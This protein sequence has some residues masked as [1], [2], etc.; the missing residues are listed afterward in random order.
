MRIELRKASATTFDWGY[1]G[2]GAPAQ[3]ALA[4]LADHLGDDEKA[5]CYFEHFMQGVIRGLPSQ[6]WA[7]TGADIDGV[8]PPW[9]V[10]R[11]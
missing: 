11:G 3:L 7:L 6:G 4:M 5:R 9:E 2:R 1:A 10:S 8:L